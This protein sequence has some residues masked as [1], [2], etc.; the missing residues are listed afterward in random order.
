MNHLPVIDKISEVEQLAEAKEEIYKQLPPKMTRSFA[1]KNYGMKAVIF[2]N[3]QQLHGIVDSVHT[4]ILDW[5][6]V[7]EKK[8]ILGEE[9]TFSEAER[10]AAQ[11][12][13]INNFEGSIANAH[14]QQGNCNTMNI[15]QC[16]NEIDTAKFLVDEIKKLINDMPQD[17]QKETLQADIE[18]VECQLKSP[19]PKMRAVKELLNS[20]RNILEGTFGSLIASHPFIAEAFSKLFG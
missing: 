9:M 17:E 4:K 10:T 16:K 14:I 6:L 2:L 18:S 3:K 20:A 1:Q 15:K 12:I 5:S 8:G 19:K 11:N 7:L 13:T